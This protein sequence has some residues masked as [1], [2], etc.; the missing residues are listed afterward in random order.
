MS[1]VPSH[2]VRQSPRSR[3]GKVE[4]RDFTLLVRVPRQPAAVQVFTDDERDEAA[5]YAGQTGGVIVPLPLPLPESYVAWCEAAGVDA[6][7]AQ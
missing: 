5:T 7:G 4:V 2:H 6:D 1:D 3:H